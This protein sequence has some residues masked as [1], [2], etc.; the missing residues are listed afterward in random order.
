MPVK[1]LSEKLQRIKRDLEDKNYMEAVIDR[2]ADKMAVELVE[3]RRNE[4][5]IGRDIYEKL[6]SNS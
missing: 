6:H 2:L 4:M 1:E 3:I 5:V